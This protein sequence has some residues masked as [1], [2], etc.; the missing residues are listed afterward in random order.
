MNKQEIYLQLIHAIDPMLV[1]RTVRLHTGDGQFNDIVIINDEL[2][3]R[4]PRSSHEAN[5]LIHEV[6][7]L[8]KIQH[9]TTLPIPNP[10]YVRTNR[11]VVNE[12]FMGYPMI[13]GEPFFNS[14]LDTIK[15]DIILERLA[16]QVA[17]FMQELHTLPFKD[18]GLDMPIFDT[19]KEWQ[20]L[21]Q[22]FH[23][24]LFPYMRLDACELVT[25]TFDA[26]LNEPRHFDYTPV[27]RH[28][29][30]GGSNI[31]YDPKAQRI[32]GVID[33]SSA[34]IGDPALD[35]AAISCSGDAFFQRVRK[36]Y[37]GMD[38][39]LERAKFYKGTFALQEALYGLR[40]HDQ[41]SFESGI[42][43]YI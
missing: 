10:M 42:A 19:Q 43:Q 13:S 41:E 26:F 11:E 28:G 37:P 22:Q 38:V 6:A 8:R 5:V 15:D 9:M 21:Y 3:F 40:D 27:F 1:V 16:A 35:V 24:K 30:F 29:D 39:L 32:T 2:I 20:D 23:D 7:V 25:H 4:F 36:A 14:I 33:F 12:N 34:G 31:L 17:R 18:I